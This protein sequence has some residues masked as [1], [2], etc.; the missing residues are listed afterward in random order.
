MRFSAKKLA[1]VSEGGGWG[2][3]GGVLGR[4]ISSSESRRGCSGQTLLM[5]SKPWRLM[6][7]GDTDADVFAKGSDQ[8]E[9]V[10]ELLQH[11]AMA[12]WRRHT[13]HWKKALMKWSRSS[14]GFCCLVL[15][16][17]WQL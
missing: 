14:P 12:G 1:A 15:V 7:Q 3:W 13:H 11:T 6:L 5:L 4:Y 2:R 17:I 10:D 9:Q 16:Q 8:L